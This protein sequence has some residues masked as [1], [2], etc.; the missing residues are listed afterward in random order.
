MHIWAYV[1]LFT[2]L[3][4]LRVEL[5]VGSNHYEL[6]EHI[7]ALYAIHYKGSSYN[8]AHSS[9]GVGCGSSRETPLL[10]REVAAAGDEG[11]RG[12]LVRVA[13]GR[14]EVGHAERGLTAGLRSCAHM[15]VE[16][17]QLKWSAKRGTGAKKRQ[18]RAARPVAA[19]KSVVFIA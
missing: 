6:A 15:R 11:G 18:A 17:T 5:I 4:T 9:T 16:P 3:F 2:P 10:L 8:K 19:R 13:D 1:P 12:V 14:A 7:V